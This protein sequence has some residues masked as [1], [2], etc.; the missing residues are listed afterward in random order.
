V[1]RAKV[2]SEGKLRS[3]EGF[4]EIMVHE[5]EVSTVVVQIHVETMGRFRKV[6]VDV[7]LSRCTSCGV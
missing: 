2:L 4:F 5:H 6:R 1:L 3:R 7:D